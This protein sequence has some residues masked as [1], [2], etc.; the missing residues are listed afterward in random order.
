M[1]KERSKLIILAAVFVVALT[2]V[3]WNHFDN[4]FHFDDSH[5]IVHNNFITDIGNLP[6]IFTDSRT[7]SSLPVNQSYRPV[8]T[9]LNT[10]DYWIAGGLDPVIFHWHIYLEFLLFLF[11]L[12]LFFRKVFEASSG[13]NHPYVALFGAA[14]FAFHTATAET[15]NYIISRS[16]GFSTL[17]VLMGILLYI[18]NTGWKKQW[19][20]I[21][22]IIGCLAK[23]T[24][25]MLAPLL[26]VYS[27]LV[28]SPSLTVI[29]EE[30]NFKKVIWRAFKGTLSYFLIGAGMYLF[31]RSMSEQWVP[32]GHSAVQYLNTQPWVIL[33]YLKTFILPV[34]LTADSDLQLISDILAPKVLVGLSFISLLLFTAW[35][36]SRRRITLPIAVGILWFYIALIPSSSIIPLA[37]VMNHHR[38]FFPYIGLVMATT[39]GAFLIF[40]HLF[41][42]KPS[43]TAIYGVTALAILIL[44]LYGYGTYQRNIVWDSSE[45]LWLDVTIKSPNNGRGLMNYGLT[46]MRKGNMLEA[47]K[48]Y[49]R[50][51]EANY[52]GHPFLYINL[53]IATNNLSDRTGDSQLKKKA[54]VYFKT[55]LLL[56]SQYPQ[57]HFHYA[58]WLHKNNRSLEALS[59]ARRAIELSPAH[60]EARLLLQQI[61]DAMTG[62]LTIA[63]DNAKMINTP[64]AYL[65]LSLKY[66]ELGEY[67]L[68][69]EASESA[70]K[71]K[72][73]YASAYN[74]ICSAFNEMK[75]YDLAAEAC[76]KALAIAPDH[77]LA[78]GNLNWIREQ[79]KSPK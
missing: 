45:S 33:I 46:E 36:S 28:E 22:F 52:G 4:E 37:E 74:N 60:K 32:G 34:G 18:T 55:A 3:Y 13:E 68:C 41:G 71:L 14:F 64:E 11:L 61:N 29:S 42:E 39:W 59:Y 67:E 69:I 24:T 48:Y 38:T 40:K 9:S 6:L 57:T 16:D 47:I 25:L 7:E 63:K 23:P 2:L 50:A 77:S 21:P 53:G 1:K 49:E 20:L 15:L 62:D 5:T 66:H 17:M 72:P 79:Q 26:L 73:D 44:G 51:K 30:A 31:T 58:D 19:G 10:V 76:E 75:Q 27:L 54:E 43:L 70:L 8:V 78:R 56:G 65:N 12:Y 35:F